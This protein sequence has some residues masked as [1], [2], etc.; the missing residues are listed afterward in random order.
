MERC[1]LLFPIGVLL[2][3]GPAHFPGPTYA[4]LGFLIV[5]GFWVWHV[6]GRDPARGELAPAVRPPRKGAD[7]ESIPV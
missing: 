5:Q 3:V 6:R 1:L 7:E 2:A 4:F